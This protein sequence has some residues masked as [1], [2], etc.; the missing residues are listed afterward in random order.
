MNKEIKETLKKA[1]TGLD[2][3]NKLIGYAWEH[4][5]EIFNDMSEARQEGKAGREASELL[6]ELDL[7]CGSVD[8]ITQELRDVMNQ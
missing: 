7:I 4:Q 2:L 3:S 6:R 1:I 8:S 5:E